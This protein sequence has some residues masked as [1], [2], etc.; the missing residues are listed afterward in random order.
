MHEVLTAGL[1][2]AAVIVWWV[3]LVDVPVTTWR[4]SA[5]LAA[6][7]G[8]WALGALPDYAV[9]V[10]F[11]AIYHTAELG[12]SSVALA[13]CASTYH[14]EYRPNTNYAY[15][16]TVS[17]PVTVFHSDNQGEPAA[18]SQES[19][20]RVH[21]G[22]LVTDVMHRRGCPDQVRGR[23]HGF[24]DRGDAVTEVGFHKRHVGQPAWRSGAHL[25]AHRCQ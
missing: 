2:L 24:A 23:R 10:A 6:T 17:S 19:G 14:P 1:C 15:T 3:P 12:P 7:I 21:R 4:L 16:Q 22:L 11:L 8:V 9:A 13:G 18:R 25:V 20:E 5:L